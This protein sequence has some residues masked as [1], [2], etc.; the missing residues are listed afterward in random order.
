MKCNLKKYLDIDINIISKILLSTGDLSQI[1]I[2]AFEFK[3]KIDNLRLILV[4]YPELLFY[5]Y[6]YKEGNDEKFITEDSIVPWIACKFELEGTF[7]EHQSTL[8]LLKEWINDKL[9]IKPFYDEDAT[10]GIFSR[11]KEN[12]WVEYKF[13]LNPDYKNGW[14][15]NHT[16]D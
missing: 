2:Q 15:Y 14:W 4:I 1:D 5:D 11:K 13:Y 7:E 12:G 9:I 3:N 10:Y 16:L 8:K 6:S